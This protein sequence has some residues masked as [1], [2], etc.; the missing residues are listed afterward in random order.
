MCVQIIV[1]I[2]MCVYS[3]L[4]FLQFIYIQQSKQIFSLLYEDSTRN[5]KLFFSTAYCLFPFLTYFLT[6][7]RHGLL[8]HI[9]L[10]IGN[11]VGMEHTTLSYF[12]TTYIVL[13][14]IFTV[15]PPAPIFTVL[16][17]IFTV[18]PL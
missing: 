7:Y 18:L 4:S 17:P 11:K 2:Y 14:P 8:Y 13:P 15:L 10:K 6:F 1:C 9:S 16:A 3:L 5:L 12:P